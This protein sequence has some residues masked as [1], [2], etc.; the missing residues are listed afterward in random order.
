[1][2][3]DPLTSSDSLRALGL[4]A[5][6][7]RLYE[8]L[9]PRPSFTVAEA[10]AL[11]GDP[12]AVDVLDRLTERGLL[13]P[14]PG[15]QLTVVPA[16]EAL[17]DAIAG[18]ER[19]LAATRRRLTELSSKFR[20]ATV[21]DPEALIETCRGDAAAL[22]W[23]DR[24]H[25]GARQEIR[26]F[27]GPPYLTPN[28]NNDK[29]FEFGHLARGVRYRVLYD[30]R[31][32]IE[33]GRVHSIERSVMAGEVARVAD[34]PMKLVLTDEP[35]AMLPLHSPDDLSAWL[36]VRGSVLYDALSALFEAYWERALPLRLAIGQAHESS[37]I[38][39]DG[40]TATERALLTLLTAGHTEDTIAE[41]LGMHR[42]TVHRHVNALMRRLDS[43]SRF[44][45]GYQAVRRGWLRAEPTV[46]DA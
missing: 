2:P 6:E 33:P 9:L 41:H 28:L 12:G 4:S 21:T 37:A 18:R 8:L 5:A 31:A 24:L 11:A 13:A 42:Q 14:L 16:G 27:D 30:R 10:V 32:V 26:T 3:T 34:V 1:M 29:H 25:Q 22:E 19:E 40:P 38:E 46:T 44:Q 35:L 15:G 36:I 17:A 7:H 39:A 45:A 43:V 20:Q 23:Q